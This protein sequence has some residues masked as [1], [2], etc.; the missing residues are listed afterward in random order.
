MRRTEEYT[1]IPENNE[2]DLSGEALLRELKYRFGSDF[3]TGLPCGELREFIAASD[4]DKELL[5]LPATN[6]RESVGITAGAWLAGKTP[7]LYMQNSGLF[8]CSNDLGSLLVAS[9]IPAIFVVSWR[10]AP[11]ETATQHLATGNATI[12]LLESFGL[13]HSLTATPED[14]AQLHEQQAAS[15]LP[16]VLLKTREKFNKPQPIVSQPA[17]IRKRTEVY[18]DESH[19]LFSREE[20]LQ[21]IAT[22]TP[23]NRAL[24]S[25]T[26][27]ISR[28]LFH[29]FDSPNQFYNAGAFGL[30]SSIALG[31]STASQNVPT[32]IVEG[33]GSVLT[34]LGNLNLIGHQQ[35]QNFLHV[36]LD[37]GMYGSCSGEETVGSELIPDMAAL[38]GYAN[39]FS[40]SS[41]DNLEAIIRKANEEQMIGPTMVHVKINQSGERQF[42]RPLG[43][44]EIARRFKT[45]F[46][47]NR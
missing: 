40:I 23:S 24:F 44:A 9:E 17:S 39:V 32:T 16:V 3:V 5:H 20:T 45:H 47:D 42:K 43:M 10:G 29:H 36:V 27:L 11:G 19:H 38:L 35:P 15:S 46:R 2:I 18:R 28:S 25:S 4:Q 14:I 33:D 26:G 31:F 37:N 13:P 34:N 12:P 41:L 8:E 7:I 30:T 22:L 21:L 1:Q 6:E